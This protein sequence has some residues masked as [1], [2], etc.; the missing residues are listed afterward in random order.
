M[1]NYRLASVKVKGF[2]G[3]PEEAGTKEFRFDE[4]CTLLLGIQGGGKSSALSA[5]E[6]CMFGN[7]VAN[8][9]DTG[10]Q[11]RKDW[12]VR[13]KRSS[14]ASVEVTFERDGELLKVY[15][16]DHKRRGQPQFYYQMNDGSLHEDEAGL[17]VMLGVELPD[18]ISCVHLHQEV[19]NALLVESPSARKN[20]LDRLMGLADLRNQLEGITRAKVP[21]KLR[22]IDSQFNSIE[23]T[24]T[25]TREIKRNDLVR[26]VN[27]AK[28]RGI[29]QEKLSLNGAKVCCEAVAR[30]IGDFTNDYGLTSPALPGFQILEDLEPFVNSGKGAVRKLRDKQ[31]VLVRQ[32]ELLERRNEL[33]SLKTNFEGKRNTL[34]QLDGKIQ[35]LKNTHG[36]PSVVAERLRKV[37]DELLPD[38]RNRLTTINNRAGVIRETLK[39]LESAKS[40]EIKECPVCQRGDFDAVHVRDHL[41][42][43]R[44]EMKDTLALIE[45]EIRNLESEQTNL[46]G[47][48]R[49]VESLQLQVSIKSKEVRDSTNAIATA[50]KKKISDTEDPLVLVTQEIAKVDEDLAAIRTAVEQSNNRLNAMDDGLEDVRLI[51]AVLNLRKG[52]DDLSKVKDSPEYKKAG[53]SRSTAHTFGDRIETIRE[54]I[55]AVLR[56]TAEAKIKSTKTAISA[57]YRELAQR[58]DYPDIEI[59]PEK[60]EVM[61]V[62]D[63]E[64]EVALRILNKGDINC[65]A[66]SIFLA[67]ATSKDLTHNIASILLDDPSQS[68]D[69]AHKER[70]A[71]IL[72]RVL[73][74]KQLVIA[75][76]EDDFGTHLRS[77]LTKKKG[78]YTMEKWTEGTGPEVKVE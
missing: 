23:Q 41:K 46:K 32:T 31:P 30:T 19:I 12:L 50:L 45:E 37:K 2:R 59:D 15:R 10:I 1:G 55:Q 65:A 40:E 53:E 17:R 16:C 8:M 35:E 56:T 61:A 42:T 43:W 22:E 57:I 68:L 7:K 62:R 58:S 64:S 70:L 13:N 5:I 69:P 51:I 27:D 29:Q 39:L 9:S 49:Q 44:E 28:A 26:A 33:N 47:V 67:L 54:A 72:N 6:W 4:P 36:D 48:I 71:N 66:L 11:E 18:Y 14:E 77:K 74:D 73:E 60:Y 63:G 34:K 75:T 24:V 38:A 20:A 52:I 3:F 25:M 78:I 76:S 21:D